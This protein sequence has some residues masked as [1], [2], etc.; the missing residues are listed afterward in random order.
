MHELKLAFPRPKA[1]AFRLWV[2]TNG[3]ILHCTGKPVGIAGRYES[4]QT[5]RGMSVALRRAGFEDIIFTRPR[6]NFTKQLVATARKPVHMGEVI[7]I[8]A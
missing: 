6:D 7:P 5:R 3:F 4:F 8:A 2:L 1:L